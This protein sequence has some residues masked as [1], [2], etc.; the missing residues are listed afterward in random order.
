MY[1]PTLSGKR[2]SYFE[3]TVY[4]HK[5]HFVKFFVSSVHPSILWK[6]VLQGKSGELRFDAEVHFAESRKKC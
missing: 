6:T 5:F 4:L 3:A 1:L 2:T